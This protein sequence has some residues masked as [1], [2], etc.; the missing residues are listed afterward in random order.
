M[1]LDVVMEVVYQRVGDVIGRKIAAMAVMKMNT[2]VVRILP[3]IAF[4]VFFLIKST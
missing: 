4:K 1:N 2:P 3:F